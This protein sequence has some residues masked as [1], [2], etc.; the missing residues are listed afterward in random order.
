MPSRPP[1]PDDSSGQRLGWGP[2]I[3]YAI[4]D[5]AVHYLYLLLVLG[6]T[7]YAIDELGLDPAAIGWIWFISK[8]WD[9]IS[10]PLVGHWSDSTE[11]RWGRR[12]PWLI[13]SAF[14]L[15]LTALALWTPPRGLDGTALIAWV[16]VVF[17][18]FFT[19]YPAFEV[20]RLA[21]GAE[22]SQQRSERNRICGTRQ[23]VGTIGMFG[24]AVFGVDY[25]LRGR[26]E[27]GTQALIAGLLVAILVVAAI[28]RLPPERKEFQGRSAENPWQ[29][30]G[31][32]FRNPHARLL[33]IVFF[34]E[35]L[36][37]GGIGMLVPFVTKYVLKMPDVTGQMLAFYMTPALLAVPVWVMLARHFEKRH[38]WLV[39]MVMG[40]AGFGMI[41]WLEEG[42]WW[43]MAISGAI[44]GTA[45]ACG[46]TLGQALK[47]DVIDYDEYVTGERKEGAYFAT[48]NF[49]RKL[50]G[51]AVGLLVGIV[52]SAV[53]YEPNAVEQTE[54]VKDAMRLLMGG[55]PLVGYGIGVLVFSRFR[56]SEAD[57]ARIVGEL[58][59]RRTNEA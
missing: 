36:G 21:L 15:A 20:P 16:G 54:A 1:E 49:V 29:A 37:S 55:L 9:A 50:A 45:G 28:T 38:L 31:G 12:R 17:L 40:G 8:V 51:G 5:A 10:D 46:N 6:Y 4:P 53:A 57:H 2:I 19:A 35:S 34:I 7:I 48:W 25:A 24:A 26:T 42:D 13:G 27:A 58:D 11:S 32:V 44:A 30:V 14:P 39:A 33:L 47:A 3:A 59:E 52:L 56:L 22:L 41:F 18:A 43:W 23:V